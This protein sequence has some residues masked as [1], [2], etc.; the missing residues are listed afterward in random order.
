M[1]KGLTAGVWS[2]ELVEQGDIVRQKAGE[3][4]GHVRVTS[5]K[6]K[7]HAE[8]VPGPPLPWAPRERSVW[9]V[10]YIFIYNLSDF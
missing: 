2:W 1:G 5:R 10:E 3:V 4:A 7:H 9:S 6:P 8:H